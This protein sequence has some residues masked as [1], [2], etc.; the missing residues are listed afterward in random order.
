MVLLTILERNRGYKNPPPT[1]EGV[2]ASTA[3]DY[4]KSVQMLLNK[5]S[6]FEG[7]R[8]LGKQKLSN[9]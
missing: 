8:Y 6:E 7:R 4:L 3:E 2:S 1:V 5:I 9:L